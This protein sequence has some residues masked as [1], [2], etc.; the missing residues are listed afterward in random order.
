[1]TLTF[2]ENLKSR[3]EAQRRFHSFATGFLRHE[4]TDYIAAVERQSRGAI[5]YHCAVAFPYDVRSG[6]DFE[7]ARRA[8]AAKR[9]QDKATYDACCSAYYRSAN[10]ALRK[11]W[12]EL[13]SAAFRYRFG[14]CETLPILSNAEGVARYVGSYVATELSARSACDKGLRTVRYSLENRAASIRWT[15]VDGAG[16]R[17]RRGCRVLS[18]VLGTDDFSSTLGKQW[19]YG[20]AKEIA[21]F[22]RHWEKCLAFTQA[23]LSDNEDFVGR[24]GFAGGMYETIV[25]HE[26]QHP[27]QRKESV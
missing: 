4:V 22:G 12:S 23:R 8:S 10:D 19:A 15:W 3:T 1:M 2:R 6:F 13:R 14:R 27:E 18:A 26:N 16:L 5:H 25:Q 24:I 11:W 7:S 17:W 21:A 20:W 9:A